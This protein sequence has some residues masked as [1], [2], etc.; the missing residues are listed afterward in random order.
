MFL[1]Y[2]HQ[3]NYCNPVQQLCVE[4][5]LKKDEEGCRSSCRGLHADVTHTDDSFAQFITN[6]VEKQQSNLAKGKLACH[7]MNLC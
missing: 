4:R 1:F 5:V 7:E 3:V 6:Q 2:V